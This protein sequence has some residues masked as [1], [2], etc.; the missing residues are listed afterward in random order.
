MC[1][2]ADDGGW[3]ACMIDEKEGTGD[4]EWGKLMWVMGTPIHGSP[5]WVDTAMYAGT[6]SD[7][8]DAGREGSIGGA[9]DSS[10][11]TGP[12]ASCWGMPP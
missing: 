1:M 7:R 8:A 12:V 3:E 2:V 9:E 11:M 5:G 10:K 6:G 4:G